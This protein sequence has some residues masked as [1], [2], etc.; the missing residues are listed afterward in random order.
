[1]LRKAFSLAAIGI[2]LHFSVVGMRWGL[3][4]LS[5]AWSSPDIAPPDTTDRLEFVSLAKEQWQKN[6]G[7][8]LDESNSQFILWGESNHCDL[9]QINLL[10]DSETLKFLAKRNVRQIFI[11][12][13]PS[14]QP[15]IDEAAVNLK[16][17][18]VLTSICGD[19]IGRLLGA[20]Y[21][22]LIKNA[23]AQGIKIYASDASDNY[24]TDF[25][26]NNYY[27][28]NFEAGP[29]ALLSQ[30]MANAWSNLGLK[31][32]LDNRMDEQESARL[33]AK[34]ASATVSLIYRGDKHI[35]NNNPH[36]LRNLLPNVLTIYNNT[37]SKL[38]SSVPVEIL[39]ESG[40]TNADSFGQPIRPP[41]FI[42]DLENAN[43][44][45]C[46]S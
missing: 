11:E 9:R 32:L 26:L 45:R 4:E 17:E 12:W 30:K 10:A 43:L 28:M 6:I 23:T 3:G 25:Y 13:P 2:C 7:Q 39:C 18:I 44:K 46:A 8:I 16:N 40:G 27:A 37:P 19:A 33:I 15:Q 14:Y 24:W 36:A 42:L 34:K 22:K 29:I 41:D 1:M 21:A 20:S 35:L 5:H 31:W 38:N